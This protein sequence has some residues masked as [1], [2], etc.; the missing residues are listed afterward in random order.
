MEITRSNLF[1]PSEEHRAISVIDESITYLR[2]RV[3]L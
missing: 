3:L 1:Q 2:N